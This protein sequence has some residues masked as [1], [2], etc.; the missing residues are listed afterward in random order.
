ML[1]SAAQLLPTP[2]TTY[3]ASCIED[4]QHALLSINLHYLPVA[5]L[6]GW[7]ILLHKDALYKLYRLKHSKVKSPRHTDKRL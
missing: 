3:C 4:F 1:S 6:Y 5:V 2:A 7:V